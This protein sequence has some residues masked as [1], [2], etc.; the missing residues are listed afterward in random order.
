MESVKDEEDSTTSTELS[1]PTESLEKSKAIET[2]QV[3]ETFQ[4]PTV[5]NKSTHNDADSSRIKSMAEFEPPQENGE[6]IIVKENKLLSTNSTVE[7]Q[8]RKVEGLITYSF[9]GHK[10]SQEISNSDILTNLELW[11]VKVDCKSYEQKWT[12]DGIS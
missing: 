3:L 12:I 9:N 5:S 7:I 11:G 4:V 10:E 6:Q 8:N 2:P 1:E